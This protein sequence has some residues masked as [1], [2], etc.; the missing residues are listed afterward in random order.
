[1]KAPHLTQIGFF[2]PMLDQLA[3][4]GTPVDSLIKRS[5]LQHFRFSGVDGYV[6]MDQL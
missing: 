6:P 4:S 5:G 2:K 1:M 3:A